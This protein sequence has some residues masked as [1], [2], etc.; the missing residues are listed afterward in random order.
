MFG[1][2]DKTILNTQNEQILRKFTPSAKTN[3]VENAGHFSFVAPCNPWTKFVLDRQGV[4][5]EAKGVDR[6][7]IHADVSKRAI[8]FF[9]R[10]LKGIKR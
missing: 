3:I 9:N 8:S 1:K 5:Q 6:Q 10:H 2:Y 4:C 7:S